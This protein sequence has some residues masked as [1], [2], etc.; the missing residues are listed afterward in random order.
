MPEGKKEAS[1]SKELIT[2]TTYPYSDPSPIPEFGRLYPYNRFDG[3]TNAGTP[4]SWEMIVLENEHIKLWINPAVGGKIWG[5]VEKRS[6]KEFIYFN[7]AAKFRD[8]AMRGPWTS[9]GMETNMGIIGHTPSCSAP[10]DYFTR[11]NADGSV[12]CFISATDWPSRSN[13]LIEINLPADTAFFLTRSSWYNNSQLE[14]SY[15]QWNNIGI[16]TNGD[17]EYVFPGHQRLGHD[18]KHFSWPQDEE[19][20]AISDY[21]QNNFGEYKSYHVVGSYAD[22]WGC[23]WHADNFGFGH[24]ATYDDKPGK[25][26]W[27]WGLS[28]YGMIW[29]DLLTDTDGQY[30]EVQSGRLFNQSIAQS[31][32]TPFKHSSFLPHSF[33][34]W[35]EYWFPIKD[36]DGLTYAN[37]QLSF[38]LTC[39][40]NG[41]QINICANQPLEGCLKIEDNGRMLL[42]QDI[43]FATLQTTCIPL[44]ISE[45]PE[46]IKVW[47]N[48]ELIFDATEQDYKLNRPVDI[49][50]GYDFES[51][52]AICIQA[53]EWERQ[54]F[55]ER[56]VDEYRLCLKK[57]PFYTAALTGLAGVYIRQ[58]KYAKALALVKKALA[59]D[60]YN[61][62]ANYLYGVVNA[63][64]GLYTDAKDG[65]SI[66]CQ[67]IQ[68]R[69]ASHTELA[70]VL[71][72]QQ[73]LTKSSSYIIKALQ[74]NV[75]N[76]QALQLEVLVARLQGKH[77]NAKALAERLIQ[78]NPLDHLSRFEFY[79]LG[80]VSANDFNAGIKS[81]MPYETYLE[82]SLF[83]FNVKQF[84]TSIEILDFAPA[85]AMVCIW[86]A[87]VKGVSG[88]LPAAVKL[89]EESTLLG[90]DF[91]FSHREEDVDAL[92]WAINT[93]DCWKFKY[94]L[95]LAYIQMLRKE[96]ALAL[97]QQCNNEPD[98]YT[99]YIVKA[100]LLREINFDAALSNLYR[101]YELAPTQWRTAFSLCNYLAVNKNWEEALQMAKKGYHVNAGNYY[102][103]LQLANCLMHTSNF[104]EGIKLLQQL[105]VL[106]N[107][108]A[109]EGRN[110]WKEIHVF[111]ALDEIKDNN[112]QQALHY[113]NEARQ[114]PENLGVGKPYEVDERLEAFIESYISLLKNGVNSTE[115]TQYIIDY[116]KNHPGTPYSSNDF[117]SMYLMNVLGT[118]DNK[119]AILSS[120][121]M[122]DQNDMAA[123]WAFSFL[124]GDYNALNTISAA[125][126]KKR[127]PL[128]YEILFEDRSFQFI[129][130]MHNRNFFSQYKNL[131][132]LQQP[133]PMLN[134]L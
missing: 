12:S 81:E 86:R 1:V 85:Y 39:T 26:I 123:Q 80:T 5:A 35:A 113:I 34:N 43:V 94:Y 125:E 87:Y 18:G 119:E 50:T 55:Y 95:A 98:S 129:K 11:S 131:I 74:Y 59:I 128:P 4:H 92:T 33:D 53:K 21:E 120:W 132:T 51:V 63:R 115:L 117:L 62:E 27:I 96:E 73:Q 36:I 41:C 37:E 23:Y 7:H 126:H 101:A 3:Y 107:E 58:V 15:Y 60:T 16:K 56:A 25:K 65:F 8:V 2:L 54:R 124:K 93:N 130:E 71:L 61:A 31:S 67:S 29:E 118:G 52:Q 70:K 88:D 83:Y 116:R 127:V 90:S 9:G 24:S 114:W 42:K 72:S 104:T 105:T 97:L 68:Y 103:G 48:D 6:G 109:S 57:D 28:R 66:A 44:Q 20:R 13:W 40:T 99:F 69:S 47:L 133:T 111:A 30:T 45:T 110:I 32:K 100:N 49:A 17:L 75:Y 64:L 10:V 134:K 76:W 77:N 19:G 46:N 89:L 112:L 14:Q 38:Y 82:L 122:H 108:G 102:L 79:K 78:A 22:F 106:P 91:V 121:L 84:E